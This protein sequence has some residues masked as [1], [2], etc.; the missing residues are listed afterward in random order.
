MNSTKQLKDDIRKTGIATVSGLKK[1]DLQRLRHK[2]YQNSTEKDNANDD[3]HSSYRTAKFGTNI[4]KLTD[5]QYNIVVSDIMS[6]HRIIA[7]AGSGKTTTTLCRIMYLIN[8]GI[9]PYQILMTTFNVDAAESMKL[10]MNELLGF[11]TTIYVGTI[12]AL[13]CR[14]YNMY[15]KRPDYIGVTEYCTEFLN[16]L[17]SDNPNAQKLKNR[18]QYVFF[19]EF[20]DCNDVQFEIVKEFSKLSYVT[21]IG[22]DAQNIYQWR[23]SNIDFILKFDDHIQSMTTD[24]DDKIISRNVQTHTLKTNFRST[25]EIINLANESIRHNTDQIPKQML[26]SK[27]SISRL[28]RIEKYKN[29]DE[30]SR[31]TLA[32]IIRYV[33]NNIPMDQIAILS[34]NNYSLK[35]LEEMIEKHNLKI[36][37]LKDQ[38]LKQPIVNYVSLINED[39]KDSKPKIMKDHI[40]LTTIHKSKGL[41]WDVVFIL[42]CNDD[43]FPSE[44]TPIK[45]QE[46]RRLFYVAV[47]RP[48]RYLNIFFTS[49]SIT[50][51]I[52][53]L[54]RKLYDFKQSDPKFFVYKNDRHIKFKHG[55]TQLIEMLEPR[56]IEFMRETELIPRFIPLNQ[57]IHKPHSYSSYISNYYL[58]AE[59]GNYIDRYVSR[60]IGLECPSS[61]GLIDSVANKVLHT[62]CLTKSQQELYSKYHNN[63]Q[64][65]L[66][67]LF[68]NITNN[69]KTIPTKVTHIL[70]KKYLDKNQL[71][72][73]YITFLDIADLI[74]LV[75][76][77]NVL[78]IRSYEINIYPSQLHIAP[79]NYMPYE[80]QKRFE[81]SYQNYRHIDQKD[82]TRDDSI[83]RDV[84]NISL[85]QNIYDGRRRLLYRD[86]FDEFNTDT[87]LYDDIDEWVR[88]QRNRNICSK[89]SLIHKS[90]AI[91]GELDLIDLTSGCETI[92]D[93]KCSIA[94]ECRLE[95]IL[96]LMMYSALYKNSTNVI[97]NNFGIYNPLLGTYTS[98]D[99]ENWDKHNE[100]LIF[101]DSIRTQRMNNI[102]DNKY[103]TR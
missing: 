66:D 4:I 71:D 80:F 76:L 31:Y 103:N 94:S 60:R 88:H 13:A 44:T 96:Q 40:T 51:Y 10:K 9:K 98:I 79:S 33:Q 22:D 65:K 48:K 6:H 93:V 53:E 35:T 42:S 5:E 92:I 64:R 86:C 61:G 25:P 62:V 8:S 38:E 72:P 1:R 84:Y 100:L 28:V 46:D 89:I 23:G 78:A 70:V 54:D 50:R 2:L 95:W 58:Q 74:S 41:E 81:K 37:S 16:F 77:I 15:F 12:D 21:V 30:Q 57:T 43:K 19:D 45:L 34:R 55:V 99:L 82:T 101:M 97:I 59:F 69:F 73:I 36:R 32:Y 85:C 90:L 26:S 27:I 68:D 102:Y 83:L 18:I 47:T 52:G 87:S 49:N 56:D 3:T 14:F 20:Q 91:S 67:K 17:R 29:E 63:I 24:K 11:N 75:E 39:T 7:C